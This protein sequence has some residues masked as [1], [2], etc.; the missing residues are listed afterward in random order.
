MPYWKLYYHLV[1]AT[2]ERRALIDVGREHILY[3][4]LHSKAKELG[5]VMHALR[6]V[7]DH[8]H[9][10]AS[11]PPVRSVADCVKHLKGASSRAVNV[12]GAMGH[13]FQWQEGYGALS[14][15][16]RFVATVVAYLRNQKQHHRDRTIINLYETTE[17][18]A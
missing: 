3:L 11:I 14:I 13:V 8:I 6:N 1:W 4:T 17:P 18:L 16:E 10:V 2:F 15:G 9:L 12:R 7:E 5:L